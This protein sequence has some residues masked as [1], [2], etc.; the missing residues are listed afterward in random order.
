MVADSQQPAAVTDHTALCASR[1]CGFVTGRQRQVVVLTCDRSAAWHVGSGAGAP[2]A[3][4]AFEP[5]ACD[6]RVDN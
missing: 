3:G 6:C 2:G 1:Y 5:K 4:H